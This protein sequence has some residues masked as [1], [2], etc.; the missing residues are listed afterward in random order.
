MIWLASSRTST[1]ACTRI[2]GFRPQRICYTR[3]YCARVHV[4]YNIY[5]YVMSCICM[6][7][8]SFRVEKYNISLNMRIYDE[9]LLIRAVCT[10]I[11]IYTHNRGMLIIVCARRKSI[12]YI[13]YDEFVVFF[14]F[15]SHFLTRSDLAR[16][17]TP[18]AQDV[19]LCQLK[20]RIT[21]YTFPKLL[22]RDQYIIM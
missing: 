5:T 18:G 9:T 21:Y 17:G 22:L 6:H 4:V 8:H 2:P 12:Y 16:W 10:Y 14:F 1:D 3:V 7:V 15:S 11:Y 19:R 20:T 13:N